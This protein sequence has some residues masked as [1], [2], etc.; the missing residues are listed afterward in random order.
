MG[1]ATGPLGGNP[2]AG[3]TEA[4]NSAVEALFSRRP[5]V[6]VPGLERIRA[7]CD[8]LG[9]PQE[10]FPA[11]HIT[12]TNGKTTIARMVSA[13]LA[14]GG[15][16]VGTYT[17]PHLQ[18]VRERIRLDGAR[19]GRAEFL[20][21][22]DALAPAIRGVEAA[23]GEMVTFFETLT[24]LALL[25]FFRAK[26][27]TGVVE[28]GMGGRLDA[29]NVVDGRVAV[30]ARVA[31]DHAE[32]GSTVTSVAREKVGIVKEGA[33]V[34]SAEQKPAV[35]RIVAGAAEELNARLVV[36]GRDFG[37]RSRRPVTGGQWLDLSGV[38]GDID[39][40]WLPL[41]GAHQATN[42]ACA[43]AA[44]E[45][46]F[47][48]AGELDP[49]TVRRGFAA[50]RSA[51]RLEY[52]ERLGAAP[53]VLDGAHNPAG[54]RALATALRAEY[55]R[56]RLVLVLGVLADKDVGGV[57][58]ELLPVAD[59]VVATEPPCP[60]AAPPDALAA[61]ARAWS[62]STESCGSLFDG[63]GVHTNGAGTGRVE[64]HWVDTAPDLAAA[65]E[66]A[67]ALAGVED[68]VVVTGSLYAVGAARDAL[69][70]P[71]G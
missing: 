64:P 39:E 22:L 37:I 59:H 62:S 69:G 45:G 27:D 47:G 36:S 51:G 34:V 17:S 38:T 12:G 20:A 58:D 28:V 6:M 24:A 30:L 40:V 43:L 57:L 26:V 68:L 10:A 50:V 31:L 32:L 8:K 13:L 70:V 71:V 67:S 49:V 42:A 63:K 44:V 18:D 7:L 21:D 65:L 19:I 61:L 16:H 1:T 5:E 29:T 41:S 11:I 2:P 52:I 4:Y 23:M 15:L 54:A 55:P 33:V 66:R 46:Y 48:L 25:R 9:S 3:D 35:A 60:R 14:S 53:V 56:R